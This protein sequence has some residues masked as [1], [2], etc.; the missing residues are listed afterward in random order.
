MK[1]TEPLRTQQ[2]IEEM[3]EINLNVYNVYQSRKSEEQQILLMSVFSYGFIVLISAI[4]IANIFNT[5]STGL[6]LRK[7]EFAM[8]KSVGMTPKGFTKMMNYESIFYG[9]KSLLFGLPVSFVVMYLIY[10]AF[11]NKFSYGFTLPWMSIL[12]VIVAVFIIVGSAM[13]YSGARVKKETI[14]D[15][16]KQENI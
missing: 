14:I 12:S 13:L 8:L 2:G 6:S 10:R 3:H 11:S 5:I 7:R 9:V 4:S 15:A 16:L 1:S